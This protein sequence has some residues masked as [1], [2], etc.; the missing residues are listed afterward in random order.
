MHC[1]QCLALTTELDGRLS[2][3]TSM[4]LTHNGRTQLIWCGAPPTLVQSA[5]F[6]ECS[7]HPSINQRYDPRCPHIQHPR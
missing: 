1:Y 6:A 5:T 7:I 2:R 3:P 4:W